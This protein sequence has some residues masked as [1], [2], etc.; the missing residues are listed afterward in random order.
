MDIKYWDSG[1]SRVWKQT[2]L[3]MQN[4]VLCFGFETIN[5]S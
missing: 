1:K 4:K 5:E 2:H 3:P